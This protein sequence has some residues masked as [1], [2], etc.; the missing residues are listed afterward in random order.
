MLKLGIRTTLA[1]AAIA[2]LAA[3]ALTITALAQPARSALA[4]SAPGTAGAITVVGEGK[5]RTD[6]NVARAT[7]GVDVMRPS[8]ADASAANKKIIDAVLSVL[9]ELGLTDK[10]LQTSG[11]SVYAER[12]GP[13]G[14]LPED[15]VNYRVT[16]NVSVT[17]RDLSKV[18]DILDAAIKAGANNIYGVEFS[19]ENRG[20]FES[21]ARKLAI[22]DARMKAE[23]LATLTGVK[24]GKVIGVSEVI[25]N[26][27][28]FAGNFSQAAQGFGGGGAPSIQPGQLDLVM[29]IQVMFEIAE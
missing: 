24:L 20:A 19:V 4:Q 9:K 11:Y 5:V 6:P 14:P 2:L 3:G 10:E 16:N 25:G 27:G 7:I 8:V 23:E 28:F 15:Q 26:V 1:V 12:Y 21:D 13:N 18:G 17:I 29:Q 22:E